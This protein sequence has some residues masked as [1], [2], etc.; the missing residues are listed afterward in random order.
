MLKTS[1]QFYPFKLFRALMLQR[2][3][4]QLQRA[5]KSVLQVKTYKNHLPTQRKRSV[6]FLPLTRETK[7]RIFMFSLLKGWTTCYWFAVTLACFYLH[8]PDVGI[9][10]LSAGISE[11]ANQA[12]NTANIMTG[13]GGGD[14]LN[15]DDTLQL[16]MNSWMRVWLNAGWGGETAQREQFSKL[17][18]FMKSSRASLNDFQ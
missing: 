16:N 7:N 17:R 3:D 9:C 1:A 8:P 18:G 10:F 14:Q 11:D 6:G 4:K 2:D 12:D 5:Y 15:F 13:W